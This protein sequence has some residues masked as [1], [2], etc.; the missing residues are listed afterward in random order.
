M[1]ELEIKEIFREKYKNKE[2]K[3]DKKTN[4]NFIEIVNASF[5]SETGYIVYHDKCNRDENWY[6][7]YYEPLVGD[8]INYIVEAI[9]NDPDTR[10]AYIAMIDPYKYHNY[11]DGKICTIGM[12]CIYRKNEKRLDY[13]V[14]MRSNNIC[15]YT[16]DSLWQCK[17]FTIIINRLITELDKEI[18]PGYMYWNAGSL[19]LYEEDFKYLSDDTQIAKELI[20]YNN[21]VNNLYKKYLK[22]KND[23]RTTKIING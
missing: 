3:F 20:E 8:Q 9:K 13:I 23:K 1:T 6:I 10:Q 21:H 12:Q 16:Q 22:N 19:H 7:D 2:F 11:S 4:Q 18:S 14:Y 17:I 15:D 5:I